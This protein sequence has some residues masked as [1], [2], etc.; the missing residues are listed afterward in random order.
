MHLNERKKA[1]LKS[2]NEYK[3]PLWKMKETNCL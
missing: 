2:M 3:A 1:Y